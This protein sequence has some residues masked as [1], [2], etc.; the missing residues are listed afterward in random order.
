MIRR[1]VHF[2]GHVQGVGFRHAAATIA[3][4]FAVS[5]YVRNLPDGGV[6]VIAEGDA[7]ELTQFI[8]TIERQMERFIKTTT[9]ENSAASGEFRDFSIRG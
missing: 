3:R 8:E 1:T 2:R 7:D 4:G 5:G 9:R 6:Q